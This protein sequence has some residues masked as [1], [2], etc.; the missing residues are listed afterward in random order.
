MNKEQYLAKRN[1]LLNKA[2]ALIDKQ[3]ENSIEKAN[4]IMNEIKE[5][6]D[7]FEEQ[8]RA[9]ANLNS[10]KDNA[11]AG[12]RLQNIVSPD[13]TA[14]QQNNSEL[15]RTAFLNTLMDKKLTQD[16]MD[17][18]EKTN[19]TLTTTSTAVVIPTTTASKIWAKVEELFPFYGD[20][21]KLN[22]KGT[23]QLIQED[24]SSS[25]S[26]Y[27]E[28][29]EVVAGDES[30]KTYSLSGCEL[31]RC[32]DV[33]WKLKEMS[34]DDFENYIVDKMARKMGAALGY[35]SVIGKGKPSSS[36]GS[37]P[38]PQGVIIALEN[39]DGKPQ[40]VE[41]TSAPTY[42]DVTT[43]FSKILSAYG[44][45]VYATNDYIWNV[46]ANITDTTGKPY[47]VPDATSG[48]VGRIFG[49]VVK[50]DDSIP[51]D[52]A[53]IGDAEQYTI[54]FNKTITLDTDENKKKRITSYLGYA[55]VDGAPVTTKAFAVLRK[56]G[57]T[58]QAAKAKK[59]IEQSADEKKADK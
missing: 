40:I 26:F 42:K 49:A 44:K 47:F 38:E 45:V 39:E 34:I 19:D 30:F 56:K 25:A 9:T 43:V 55:I 33:S 7:K 53:L 14:V 23:Y 46:L 10:L 24:A 17:I 54:N 50:E 41:Y 52:T 58:S 59:A 37:K 20:T 21:A 18:F 5:L 15:Y 12:T 3:D 51:A 28:N 1:E 29:D 13:Q 2:Q 36:D 6:D 4:E 11:R 31:S 27:E 48:G 22:I 35:A 8:A 57:A 32:I 16:E